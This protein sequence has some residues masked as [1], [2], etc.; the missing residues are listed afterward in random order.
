MG[1]I[2][3]LLIGALAGFIASI[4]MGNRMGLLICI[5][6]G[7]VGGFLGSGL[8]YILKITGSGIVWQ[9]LAG[10]VGSMVL[11]WLISLIKKK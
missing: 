8:L 9:L 11:L 5:L 6:I 1:I 10:T 7:I 4:I 3:S 2:V